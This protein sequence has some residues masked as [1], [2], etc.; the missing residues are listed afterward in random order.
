[1]AANLGNFGRMIEKFAQDRRSH[2]AADVWSCSKNDPG[3]I[4]KV[5][6]EFCRGVWNSFGASVQRP[7]RQRVMLEYFVADSAAFPGKCFGPNYRIHIVG[8]IH[9]R[10]VTMLSACLRPKD[11]G[12]PVQEKP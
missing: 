2:L 4:C 6:L 1:M 3:S 9:M 7:A 12:P 5:S 10:P 11:Y 8:V